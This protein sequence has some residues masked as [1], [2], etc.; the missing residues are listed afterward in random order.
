MSIF[1]PGSTRQNDI[2]LGVVRVITGVIFL[3]HGAQ[4]LFV[5]GLEG[6]TGGFAQMGIPMA[7]VVAPLVAL[8]EFF[9]GIALIGGLL[10]RPVSLALAFNMLGA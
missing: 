1:H 9:G 5:F 10:T 4:K 7:G 6:V 8:L 2:A 3:A